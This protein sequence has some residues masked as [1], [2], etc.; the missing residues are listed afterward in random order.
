[1]PSR[2]RTARRISAAAVITVIPL[3]LTA[4]G[5]GTSQ[6]GAS[7]AKNQLRFGGTVVSTLDPYL[8]GNYQQQFLT[9]LY[10][11][12]LGRDASGELKPG[13]ATDWKLSA[14]G[15]SFDVTL[16]SGVKFQ[17]GA[18][19]T[20]DAVKR[21]IERGKTLPGSKVASAL[22]VVD[23][24]EAVDDLHARFHLNGPPGAV[25]NILA[26]EA[27]MIISPN[28]LNNADL[29]SKP[30]GTGAY[31]LKSK[32]DS[33]VVYTAWDGYWDKAAVK[34]S[35]LDYVEQ[36]DS[37]ARFRALASGQ[38]DLMGADGS[39]IAQGRT[40]GLTVV[41]GDSTNLV[42]MI[43][44]PKAVP[45]FAN[46]LVRQAIMRVIDRKSIADNSSFT[47]ACTPA[48]QPFPP[49][50]WAHSDALD[51]DPS[52]SM[53]VAAAKNLLAQAGYPDG[54]SFKLST[55]AFPAF[56]SL[57]EILQA[58]LKQIG[59]DVKVD[60][61]DTNTYIAASAQGKIDAGLGQYATG[62]PDPSV[63]LHDYYLPGGTFNYGNVNYPGAVDLLT[64]SLGATDTKARSGPTRDLVDTITKTGPTLIPIC[65]LKQ[66]FLASTKVTG[67]STT[68]LQEY[69]WRGVAVK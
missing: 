3:V 59:I 58:Q 4:C 20:A 65:S 62:R 57:D 31:T 38:L 32:T 69:D 36:Q 61:Q 56:K 54:F 34:N 9:P 67:F 44:N 11:S 14:D 48:V 24:V 42:G 41:Q 22:K 8:T 52:L 17:D 33:E 46:P 63:F 19:L 7:G 30:D 68:L 26:S 50:Y 43:L 29:G 27:G 45:Q 10:E 66:T 2:Y 1:M 64:K 60:V 28:A 23:S 40:A 39:Q 53:D 49:G 18:P 13:L 51:N 21:S 55:I 15:K 6:D 37:T 16:H 25:G 47:G 12:V 5:G 35:G